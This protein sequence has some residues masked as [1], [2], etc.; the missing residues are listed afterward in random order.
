LFY[1]CQ[2]IVQWRLAVFAEI[3]DD[4]RD[5]LHSA[6]ASREAMSAMPKSAGEIVRVSQG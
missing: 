1:T 3:T 6:L 5:Y 2:S 4:L